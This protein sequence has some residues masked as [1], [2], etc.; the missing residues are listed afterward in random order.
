[1]MTNNILFYNNLFVA[2]MYMDLDIF[3]LDILDILI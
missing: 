3:A 1:M 2:I